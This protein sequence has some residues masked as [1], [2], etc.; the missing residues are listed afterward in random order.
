MISSAVNLNEFYTTDQ[1]TK[2]LGVTSRTLERY[3][4]EGLLAP[5]RINRRRFYSIGEI[6]AI[7]PKRKKRVHP[8]PVSNEGSSFDMFMQAIT[9]VAEKAFSSNATIVGEIARRAYALLTGGGVDQEFSQAMG[10]SMQKIQEGGYTPES[11]AKAAN[12]AIMPGSKST[13]EKLTEV[14]EQIRDETARQPIDTKAV[15]KP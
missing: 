2:V 3:E 5:R 14:F 4:K 11:F 8:E 1:A 6:N 15:V 10:E 7:T 9:P 12:D 13:E